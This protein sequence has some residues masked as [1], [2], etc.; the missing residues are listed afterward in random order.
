[1]KSSPKKAVIANDEIIVRY[2][3]TTNG[4]AAR[5]SGPVSPKHPERS[6]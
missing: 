5:P 4:A 6:I 1:M 3:D 2:K